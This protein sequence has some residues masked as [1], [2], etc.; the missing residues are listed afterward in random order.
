MEGPRRV[1]AVSRVGQAGAVVGGEQGSPTCRVDPFCEHKL[2]GREKL[3][4]Q[5]NMGTIC[6]RGNHLPGPDS[7]HAVVGQ[8]VQATFTQTSR[9]GASASPWAPC[10]QPARR[11]QTCHPNKDPLHSPGLGNRQGLC[12]YEYTTYHPVIQCFLVYTQVAQ[13]SP[14]NSRTFSITPLKQTH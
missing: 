10:R 14:P 8:P 11:K 2:S 13:L 6:L 9:S 7:L 1:S 4:V 3:D 5:L 12:F